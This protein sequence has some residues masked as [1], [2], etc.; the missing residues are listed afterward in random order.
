MD[1]TGRIVL[2]REARRAIAWKADKDVV[3]SGTPQPADSELV[4][5]TQE[6]QEMARRS[7]KFAAGQQRTETLSPASGAAL[8]APRRQQAVHVVDSGSRESL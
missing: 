1:A 8:G 4:D 7:T 5:F 3:V 2:P 6:T